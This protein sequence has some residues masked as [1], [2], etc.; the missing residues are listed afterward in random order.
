MTKHPRSI[1]FL[2][3]IFISLMFAV[4]NYFS[5]EKE[6]PLKTATQPQA[7]KNS[8]KLEIQGKKVL[9]LSP[10]KE[11]EEMDNLKVANTPSPEWKQAL[12]RSIRAQG[13]RSLKDVVF[14]PVD[15]FIWAHEGVALFVE[16][17]IVTIKNDKDEETTFRVLV[18]AQTG[19]ILQNWDRPVIDP[20]NPRSTFKVKLDPRY[21]AE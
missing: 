14:N 19:K 8:E 1:L 10:G 7:Q 4:R 16:S 20:A 21:L 17:V 6:V 11:K 12:E 15:S 9:G 13:G 18:D 3:V 5:S 2:F